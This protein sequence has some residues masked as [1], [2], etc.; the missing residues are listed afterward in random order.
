MQVNLAKIYTQ[1]LQI[2]GT[3]GGT[4]AEMKALLEMMQEHSI[5]LPTDKIFG[6]DQMKEAIQA[7]SGR[8]N[9]RILLKVQ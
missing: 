4:V 7:Y 3:T 1:E 9:G 2:I 6:I 5:H 8:T